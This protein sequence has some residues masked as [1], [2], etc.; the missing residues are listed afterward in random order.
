MGKTTL[1]QKV[2]SKERCL[3][4]GIKKKKKIVGFYIGLEPWHRGY[5][6]RL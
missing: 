2:K 4:Q 3:K 6:E 1:L 5:H